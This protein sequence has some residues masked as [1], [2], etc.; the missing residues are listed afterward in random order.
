M[1]ASTFLSHPAFLL[2]AFSS[3]TGLSLGSS[4][5]CDHT[6]T[7]GLHCLPPSSS[8]LFLPGW[9]RSPKETALLADFSLLLACTGLR[10]PGSSEAA[11]MEGLGIEGSEWQGAQSVTHTC[12]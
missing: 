6:G 5:V 3:F 11:F 12:D 1:S 8:L 10:C 7:E 2:S 9:S 4:T